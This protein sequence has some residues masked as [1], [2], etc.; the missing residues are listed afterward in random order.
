FHPGPGYGDP[1]NWNIFADWDKDGKIDILSGTQQGNVYFH[2]NLGAA[3]NLTYA[4]GVKLT[5]TNGQD[6]KVGPPVYSDPS[7][8]PDFTALQGSRMIMAVADFDHDGIDDMAITETYGNIWIF[9]NTL[10]GGTSTLAPGV[11]VKTGPRLDGLDIIDYN[12][13]SKPDLI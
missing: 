3:N 12:N 4:D 13:D 11:I 2:K 1:Y 10:V 7:Q 6:L 5:L 9:R 8:V